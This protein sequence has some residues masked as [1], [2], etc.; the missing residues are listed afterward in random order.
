MT[1]GAVVGANPL[2]WILVPG[3]GF[4]LDR[5]SLDV[6]FG[7]IAEAG[8]LSV[9]IDV[10]ASMPIEEYR[11]FVAGHGLGSV[12][13]YLS[14]DFSDTAGLDELL[15]HAARVAEVHSS[16]GVTDIFVG[17]RRSAERTRHP[18]V[19]WDHRADRLDAVVDNLA[20]VCRV[21]VAG[22]VHPAL[23]PHIATWI[24]T[25]HDTTTVLDAIDPDLLGFGP[26]IGHL[27]WAGMDAAAMID[28]YAGRVRTVHVKD[29][30]FDAVARARRADADY[31]SSA[32]DFKVWTEPGRG[33][34]DVVAAIDAVPATFSGAFV[35]EVD[36]PN[37][38]TAE[39][40]T[41]AS[42]AWFRAQPRFAAL[43]R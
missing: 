27:A 26:D 37:L 35:L 16:L 12:P 25:E 28:R 5:A 2:P 20:A 6:A 1:G 30:D 42:A 21:L 23:H 3:Q 32:L 34:A 18:G 19:G 29:V 40:S 15:E 8:F 17:S 36:V 41:V 31:G 10:P 11:R 22:G 24:E 43:L 39:A 7:V 38:P 9:T 4:H 33:G 13:G 14:A